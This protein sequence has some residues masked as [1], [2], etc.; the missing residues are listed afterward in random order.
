MATIHEFKSK[1]A[2]RAA[3]REPRSNSF[4]SLV[5]LHTIS[6]KPMSAALAIYDR[7]AEDVCLHVRQT[8][9]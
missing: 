1:L 8:N 7:R 9:L 3:K 4:T 5:R 2:N 6:Q